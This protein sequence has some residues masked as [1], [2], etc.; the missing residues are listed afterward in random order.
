MREVFDPI[1]QAWVAATPEEVVRQ[2]WIQRMIGSL[3]FPKELLSVEKELRAVAKQGHEVPHRRV[4]V[5]AFMK[6]RDKFQPLLLME[7]KEGDLTEA[8]LCQVISYNYYVQAPYVAIVNG[9]QIQLQGPQ[10]KSATLPS[11]LELIQGLC[12]V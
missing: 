9:L 8:A 6:D 11:Y 10:G 2:T 3:R 12:C 7:C 4:D 1:R 5:L